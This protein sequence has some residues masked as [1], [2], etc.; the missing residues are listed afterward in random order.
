MNSPA[1]QDAGERWSPYPDPPP[2]EITITLLD[3]GIL[4]QLA[5]ATTA[6]AGALVHV[7]RFWPEDHVPDGTP[8]AELGT[9]DIR[10]DTLIFPA[11]VLGWSLCGLRLNLST[12]VLPEYALGFPDEALCGRCLDRLGPTHRLLAYQRKG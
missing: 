4:E 3:L 2:A 11:G 6:K 8:L 9:H 12:P 10:A 5:F 7:L 1:P